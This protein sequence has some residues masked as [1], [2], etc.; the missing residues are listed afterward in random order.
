MFELIIAG[1]LALLGFVGAIFVHKSGKDAQKVDA[2][3]EGI[4]NADEFQGHV[5]AAHG[6][7]DSD[8]VPVDQDPNNRANTHKGR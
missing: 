8:W 4:R 1:I 7:D 6:V 3:E 5:D 2:Y